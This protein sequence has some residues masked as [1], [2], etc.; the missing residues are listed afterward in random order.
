VHLAGDEGAE[1]EEIEGALQEAGGFG[2]RHG[3]I[4]CL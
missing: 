2:F 3:S 1:D 4:E